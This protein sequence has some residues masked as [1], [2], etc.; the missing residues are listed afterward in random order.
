MNL[1][2]QWIATEERLAREASSLG[3]FLW[4]LR[5]RISSQLIGDQAWQSIV[6]C[7]RNLPATMAAFP[8]GFE[9]PL[10][11]SLAVADFGVS[12][13]GGG[14]SAAIL[15][16]QGRTQ[17]ADSSLAKIAWLF[18]ET[19][20]ENSVLRRVAGR[21]MLLEY[22]IDKEPQATP[23][24]PGI[25]LYPDKDVL[26]GDG[27]RQRLQELGVVV[28]AVAFST[29]LD[30]ST[31][32]R[33]QIEK[34]FLSME[35]HTCVRAVGAFP[36]RKGGIRL[37]VTGFKKAREVVSFLER[38]EWPGQCSIIDATVSR[39]EERDAFA[40]AGV[41]FDIDADGVGPTLGLSFYAREG[42]W[43][44]DVRHW[45]PLIDGVHETGLVVPK[46]LEELVN[47]SSGSEPLSG[48]SGQFLLV[49]GIHHIKLTL[50]QDR[51]EQVK[52]YVF[53]LTFAWPL[54]ASPSG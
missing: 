11:D 28:D 15:E 35:P 10:H 52:G 7:A 24:S 51:I 39:L 50:V 14:R 13:I 53:L 25:F 4:P 5:D 49:K 23:S 26:I 8:F 36:S 31:E 54:T 2:N 32:E 19:E 16:E 45:A 29:G 48:R 21:K 33:G 22:D 46:K 43:L 30:L 12:V 18:G 27:A 20:S 1:E 47:W 3:E 38:T 42:Q 34:I 41:H 40:Y 17:D 6:E 44:K 9:L 37:A